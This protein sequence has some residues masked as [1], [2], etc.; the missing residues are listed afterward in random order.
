[1]WKDRPE[2]QQQIVVLNPGIDLHGNVERQQPV[3][4]FFSL[5]FPKRSNGQQ[6]FGSIPFVIENLQL[7]KQPSPLSLV[8]PQQLRDLCVRHR[9]M[10]SQRD[11]HIDRLAMR[12]DFPK[13][14]VE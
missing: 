14:G 1:M 9:R 5:F 13:Q 12:S 6:P 7:I 11:K 2:N 10:S 8:N 3:R 4:K